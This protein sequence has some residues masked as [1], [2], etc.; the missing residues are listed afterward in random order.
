MIFCFHVVC[1]WGWDVGNGSVH[2]GSRCVTFVL[3][4]GKEEGGVSD[5][6]NVLE[7]VG[8]EVVW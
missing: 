2:A 1:S 4:G 3:E 7:W 6:R 8:E 5:G